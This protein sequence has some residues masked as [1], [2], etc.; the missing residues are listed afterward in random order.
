ML[1]AQAY[2]SGETAV[3]RDEKLRAFDGRQITVNIVLPQKEKRTID[4]DSYVSPSERAN[5]ADE[6]VRSLRK[7]DRV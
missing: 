7:N 1:V 6:Y 5:F 4:F 2:V 3:I